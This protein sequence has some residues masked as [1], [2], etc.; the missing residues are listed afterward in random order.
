M[1]ERNEDCMLLLRREIYRCHHMRGDP[2]ESDA[3]QQRYLK[4]AYELERI[5]NIIKDKPDA[6]IYDI[7]PAL[8]VGVVPLP[9]G[10][11]ETGVDE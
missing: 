1:T 10:Q 8:G 11:A 6:D 2:W 7:L 3:S 5:R 4:K 9:D